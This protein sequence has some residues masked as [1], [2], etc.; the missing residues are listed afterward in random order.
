[1]IKTNT[2]I[3]LSIKEKLPFISEIDPLVSTQGSQVP[4]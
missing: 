4:T 2:Q 3:L 1:M